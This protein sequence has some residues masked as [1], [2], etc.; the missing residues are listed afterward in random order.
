MTSLGIIGGADGATAIIFVTG[1]DPKFW[2]M[3]ALGGVLAYL[4]GSVDF[5]ILAITTLTSTTTAS[6]ITIVIV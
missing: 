3:L 1:P 6:T 5:G 4:L 2:V